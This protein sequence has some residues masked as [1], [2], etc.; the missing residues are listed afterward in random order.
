MAQGRTTIAH[1]GMLLAAKVMAATVLDLL[2]D[3]QALARCRAEFDRARCAQPYT[4]P[5]PEGVAPSKL[6]N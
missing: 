6:A 1:K 5:I 2:T 4:C 3:K